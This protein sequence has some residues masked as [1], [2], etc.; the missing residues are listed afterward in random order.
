[1]SARD[2][3]VH[4]NLF[5]CLSDGV[6]ATD[7]DGVIRMTNRAFHKMFGLDPDNPVVGR[8]FG[9]LFLMSENFDEFTEVVLDAVAERRE[10]PRRVARIR[11]GDGFRSLS[12]TSSCLMEGGERV[13]VIV[14]ASDI[15][16]IQ[17]LRETELRQA[18]VIEAQL[19]E[20]QAAYSDL[21]GRNRELSALT[22]RL[23][24]VRGAA[25]LA[26]PLLFLAIGAWYLQPLDYFS[27]GATPVAPA[28]S[29]SADQAALPSITI[30]PREF[31]ST[32][33][34]RGALSPGRI[35]RI[36]SPIESLV[37]AVHAVPGD[38][39]SQGDLLAELDT[40]LLADEQRRAE[41]EHIEARE[42]LLEIENWEN[43]STMARTRR[44]LRRAKIALDDAEREVS[45]TSFLLEQG[46][47]PSSQQEQAKRQH[48]S[49]MLDLEEAE[50]E[51]EAVRAQGS[52]DEVRKARL[53]AIS[54]EERLR[55]QQEKLNLTRVVAPFSGVVVEQPGP[56]YQAALAAGQPVAPGQ[57]LLSIADL[58]R[59]RVVTSVNEVDFRKIESGQQAR[60]T[61][62]GFP[63]LEAEGSVTSVTSWAGGGNRKR[64][65]PEFEVVVTLNPLEGEALGRL[66]A[67][68][69]AYVTIVVYQ[70]LEALMV[71]ID[72]VGQGGGEAWLRVA[73]SEG[74]WER[75]PVELGLT[76]LDS[77]EVVAGLSPGERIVLPQ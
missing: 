33:A 62:P 67:G 55:V 9:E 42:R 59:L 68:M 30:Q 16:E 35:E 48:E 65:A 37:T 61:G 70:N 27:A 64:G 45:N 44:A 51:L 77:V 54:A 53:Q 11:V 38:R 76:A 72:A 52:D 20:I 10:I 1:M 5:Q 6:L 49:R 4:L 60:I 15:T 24:Q 75:R 71:P 40:G 56:Q 57:V 36:A 22:R 7:F 31:S 25:M 34:L 39:V 2:P 13:A 66:V 43:S 58:E 41:V 14:V 28:D 23:R 32:I 18:E 46:I 19:G 73:D 74:G 26:G 50:R 69:S 29:E 3:N 21:E 12:V 8:G 47:I 17:E 63:G